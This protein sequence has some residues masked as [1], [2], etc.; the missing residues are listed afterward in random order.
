M[1][2]HLERLLSWITAD[3]S[4]GDPRRSGAR[5]L[6]LEPLEQRRLLAATD[7]ASI[8][9]MVFKDF[10]GDGYTA[11][12][13]VAGAEVR[14]YRDD[15]TNGTF[16]PGAGDALVDTDTTDA[17]GEYRFDGLTAA[18]YFVQQITQ[19]IG[20]VTLSEATSAAISRSRTSG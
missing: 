13:E 12:E 20:S 2:P 4:N 14:L 17:A 5:P 16:E 10:S 11:G 3:T 15:N 19:T 9:G 6:R 18:T 1:L 7:M 8:T